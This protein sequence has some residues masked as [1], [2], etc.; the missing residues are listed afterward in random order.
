MNPYDVHIVCAVTCVKCGKRYQFDLPVL[1]SPWS[2]TAEIRHDHI[3]K[4]LDEAG[5]VFC[6]SGW[7][8]KECCR[9]EDRGRDV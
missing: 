1:L 8:H 5:F 4:A 2:F 9:E 3:N 6:N 7:M